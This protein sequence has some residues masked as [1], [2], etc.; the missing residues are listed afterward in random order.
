ME[1]WETGISTLVA[2][3]SIFRV[4]LEWDEEIGVVGAFTIRNFHHSEF[5]LKTLTLEDVPGH[6]RLHFICNSWVYPAQRYKKD[7]IFFT[8]KVPTCLEQF[9]FHPK[10]IHVSYMPFYIACCRPTFQS[11]HHQHYRIIEKRNWRASEEMELL[12]SLRN[13]TGSM[14]MMSTMIYQI[15]IKGQNMSERFLEDQK[16]F[17]ILAEEEQAVL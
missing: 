5:Y 6:G 1:N 10:Y 15:H 12:D 13:G 3:D 14:I 8:S 2:E 4:T 7:R 16:G 9:I 17:R 11:K